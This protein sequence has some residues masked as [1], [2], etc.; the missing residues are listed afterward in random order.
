MIPVSARYQ[1]TATDYVVV[2][3]LT[4]TIKSVVTGQAPVTVEWKKI[5]QGQSKA[6]RK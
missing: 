2:V 3:T 6:N 1:F 4:R 5:P